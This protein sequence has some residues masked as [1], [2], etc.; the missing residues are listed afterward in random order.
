MGNIR[1]AATRL[2]VCPTLLDDAGLAMRF[3]YF[4]FPHGSDAVFE[5]DH[6]GYI[7]PRRLVAAQTVLAEKSG[8]T[9]VRDYAMRITPRDSHA[10]IATAGGAIVTAAKVL[11]A[12]GGFTN[13]PGLLPEPLDLRVFGRTVTFFEV[14]DAEAGRLSAMPSLI[15]EP[16]DIMA[17]IYLLPPIRYPDGKFYLKIGG[18]IVDIPLPTHDDVCAWFRRGGDAAN[19]AHLVATM[20]QLMPDLSIKA[21]TNTT[22]V[23]AY[24][25]TGYPAIGWTSQP[26][27]AVMAGGCGAAAKS[28]DE[29]GRL[30]AE[31][32]L[33]GEIVDEAYAADF[34][35]RFL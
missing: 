16:E 24:T 22:C 7:S 18:D 12:A 1:A 30:G 25:P 2:G 8:A 5:P 14:D 10:E 35:P 15:Y 31:L 11:V 28:S 29:I 13:R 34:T 27:I 6:A 3:P 20:R 9:L 32:L 33:H 26:S 23:T 21:I 19:H 4:D 17:G